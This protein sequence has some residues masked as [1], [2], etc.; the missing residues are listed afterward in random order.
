LKEKKKHGF[1]EI[2]SYAISQ[3]LIN[4]SVGAFGAYAFFFYETEV[5]LNITLLG[6][7]FIVYSIW[8]A[9]NEPLLCT[10]NLSHI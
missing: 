2:N 4:F 9:I 7:L 6:I 3:G 10:F 5:H 8:D 1:L